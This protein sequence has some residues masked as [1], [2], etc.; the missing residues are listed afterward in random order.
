MVKWIIGSVVGV[1]V[2]VPALVVIGMRWKVSPVLTAV[3]RFNR[4]VTNPGVLRN[5]G[6]PGDQNAVIEHVGRTSGRPYRTPVTVIPAKSGFLIALPYGTKADW[7]RNVL[8]AGSATIV[9]DGEQLDVNAPRIV[10]TADVADLL[11]AS[12]RRT[13]RVFGVGECL[14]LEKVSTPA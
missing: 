6:S 11:P 3:R 13:L 14:H 12:T 4:K 2:A 8:A 1:I 9:A 5:A 7:L 10:A